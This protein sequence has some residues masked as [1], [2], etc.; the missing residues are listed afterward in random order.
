MGQDIPVTGGTLADQAQK[1][2]PDDKKK[3]KSKHENFRQLFEEM[4]KH[5]FTYQDMLIE[6]IG[7]GK[8]HS[9]TFHLCNEYI[10]DVE[11]AFD[12]IYAE[13]APKCIFQH[14]LKCR[15]CIRPSKLLTLGSSIHC[16]MLLLPEAAPEVNTK[17]QEGEHVVKCSE[18]TS[19]HTVWSDLGL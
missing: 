2:L 8:A 17:F 15:V 1:N 19:F 6:F 16:G 7:T 3:D 9:I 12:Y 4:H 11:T 14:L 5:L 18:N 10:I 13:K